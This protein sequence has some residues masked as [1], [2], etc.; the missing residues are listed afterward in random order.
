[1]KYGWSVNY[2]L[3][4]IP[5]N[6]RKINFS[7]LQWFDLHYNFISSSIFICFV[8]PLFSLFSF[9]YLPQAKLRI[10]VYKVTNSELKT[11][12]SKF[13]G[14]WQRR[15]TN[16]R[17]QKWVQANQRINRLIVKLQILSCSFSITTMSPFGILDTAWCIFGALVNHLRCGA[18]WHFC[19]CQWIPT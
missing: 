3:L 17:I 15:A 9:F 8:P 13:K 12:S 4:R 18:S 1:M 16:M 10:I 19:K 14:Q 7:L 6:K 11:Q 5:L 2:S